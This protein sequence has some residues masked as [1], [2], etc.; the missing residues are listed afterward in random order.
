MSRAEIGV[1]A[2]VLLT[3]LGMVLVFA[4][5]LTPSAFFPGVYLVG[6]GLLV[7]AASGL[8]AAAGGRGQ[9]RSE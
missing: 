6:A 5:L 9:L 2:G 1:L 8:L 7:L 3:G 4:G